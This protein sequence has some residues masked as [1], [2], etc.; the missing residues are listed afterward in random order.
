MTLSYQVEQ[1]LPNRDNPFGARHE[2][3]ALIPDHYAE[4]GLNQDK[5]KLN[6]YWQG[7]AQTAEHDQLMYVTIRDKGKLVGYF[8]GFVVPELHYK[9]VLSLTM[10]I[11]YVSP[12]YRHGRAGVKLFQRVEQEAKRRGVKRIHVG[13]KMHKDASSLF[14]YLKYGPVETYYS[15][16]IGD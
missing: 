2:L 15:K 16:W 9:D 4:L 6:P 14:K 10:D 11:F 5:V 8:I 13:S 3:E 12:E 7:Y 1:W